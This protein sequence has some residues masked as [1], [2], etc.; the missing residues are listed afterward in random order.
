[1]ASITLAPPTRRLCDHCGLPVGSFGYRPAD[2][3]VFCCYGCHLA[4]RLV[5]RQE[6]GGA[7][8]WILLRLGLGAF[9]AMNVMMIS[10]L[11]YS[12]EIQD[13]GAGVEPTLRWALLAL[14]TP[15]LLILGHPFAVGMAREL[16]RA[17]PSIDSLIALG[18]LSAYGVSAVHV[19]QG[20]G[21]IYFDTATMLLLLVTV[22]KL[23]EASS[24]SKTAG[25][26]RGLLERR[27]AKARVRR[28]E[29]LLIDP[30]EV[31]LGEWVR[32]RPGER[33]PVDG[34]IV[35][36]RTTVHEAEFTGESQPRPAAPGT[37]VIGG[38]LNGEGE[39]VVAARAVGEGSLLAQ[40]VR[41]VEQSAASR[42]PV[43]RLAE[44]VAAVFVP[45]VVLGAAGALIFWSAR[46][47]LAR[48]GMAALAILVVACP[49]ALGI[50]TPLVTSLAIGRAAHEGVLIR[51][52]E[53][54]ELLPKI[55]RMFFDKTGTLTRGR[56]SV[57]EVAATGGVADDEALAWLATL[58]SAAEH[59]VGRAIV[60]ESQRRGLALGSVED[61]RA[62]PGQ[63]ATGV[64][65]LRDARRELTAGTRDFLVERGFTPG[66]IEEAEAPGRSHVYGAWREAEPSGAPVLLRVALTDS[67]RPEAPAVMRALGEQGVAVTMLSGDRREVA[68]AVAQQAGIAEVL[69]PC[70]PDRKLEA[71][72][73]AQADGQTVAMVGDGLNDAPALAAADV[74]IALAGG[75]DLARES[76]DL[77]L[78]GDDLARV[79]WV[80]G[81]AR[82]AYRIVSGNLAWAFGY[83]ALA[84]VLAF[85]GY[86]HP[87][88]AVLVMLGSSA[89]VLANSLRVAR[90]G[91]RPTTPSPT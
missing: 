43:E 79:P 33:I 38:S 91:V 10:L 22:G 51:S 80:I 72:R 74:G 40:I 62:Y 18:S 35:S 5:G 87:L 53:A 83:N 41:L 15:A 55:G 21:L 26:V 70:L 65:T 90:Y 44:R 50:A 77:T 17:R 49:C 78:L 66:G 32:V 47:D 75:T 56:M 23:L 9:L 84:L 85:F 30:E 16:R 27:P 60:A 19:V 8:A 63:G 73:A 2:D 61:Y 11:L 52:G 7:P 86:L 69:A 3:R 58:E 57:A 31:R 67:L 42:A 76:G 1:M 64:V 34:E 36:G 12:G 89:F 88:F 71:L 14:A 59:P 29:E 48:G 37:S 13:L 4:S 68:E 54:L 46:G 25:L 81:L 45:I 28:G 6:E 39:I 82:H 20:S 24:K